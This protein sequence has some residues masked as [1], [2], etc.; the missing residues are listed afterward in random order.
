MQN[1]CITDINAS[2]AR[3]F[4]Q[5]KH[6]QAYFYLLTI[7]AKALV[8]GNT[9]NVSFNTL[10][11]GMNIEAKIGR[12][13]ELDELVSCQQ[14]KLRDGI[15]LEIL[16]RGRNEN[17]RKTIM[18]IKVEIPVDNTSN[19][20]QK[21][22][23]LVWNSH[24]TG[25]RNKF[26]LFDLVSSEFIYTPIQSKYDINTSVIAQATPPFLRIT[27]TH[28]NLDLLFETMNEAEA[29]RVFCLRNVHRNPSTSISYSDGNDM[30]SQ[31]SEAAE[32][33]D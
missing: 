11:I 5:D 31:Q 30:I 8:L 20:L 16:K 2:E 21:Y 27:N 14:S 24:W 3:I 4:L 19:S 23:Y 10:K 7:G 18:K 9:E 1:N 33:D 28:R 13:I 29:F 32:V 25:L 22:E 15:G 17:I 12:K 6:E 26:S